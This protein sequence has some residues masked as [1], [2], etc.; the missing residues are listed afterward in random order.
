MVSDGCDRSSYGQQFG[1]LTG[2]G[3]RRNNVWLPQTPLLKKNSLDFNGETTSLPH[4]I[5]SAR[6]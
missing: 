3:T 4:G 1:G 2:D 5:F 6:R